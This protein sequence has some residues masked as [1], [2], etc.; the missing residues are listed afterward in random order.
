MARLEEC[1]QL[2]E[3]HFKRSFP[4]PLVELDL[5]GQ[6]AGVAYLCRNQLRFNGQMYRDHSED[7][8]QQTVPHEVAH[9]LAHLIYG[10]MIKPHG[11]EWRALMTELYQLPAKRCHDY[12]VKRRG[13]SYYYRCGCTDDLPFTAQRHALV[14]RGRQYQ[15]RRCGSLLHYTGRNDRPTERLAAAS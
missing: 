7:F 11:P 13:A 1:Y 14:R 15:C 4:R 5:R 3:A 6:R 10:P 8:L 2:A 9:L 12:P